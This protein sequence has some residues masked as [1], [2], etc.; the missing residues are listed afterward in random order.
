MPACPLVPSFNGEE[1]GKI[2]G[3]REEYRGGWGWLRKK[4][5]PNLYDSPN[6]SEKYHQSIICK[7]IEMFFFSL[8]CNQLHLCPLCFAS[9]TSHCMYVQPVSTI[10]N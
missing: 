7:P 3:G 5:T 4:I 9:V 6:I 1:E 8:A 2:G 10:S